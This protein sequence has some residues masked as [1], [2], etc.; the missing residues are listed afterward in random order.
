MGNLQ[1]FLS[2]FMRVAGSPQGLENLRVSFSQVVLGSDSLSNFV[3]KLVISP[4]LTNCLLR[5]DV[6]LGW[7]TWLS[8][9]VTLMMI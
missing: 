9:R 1:D 7:P 6:S 4:S 3:F 8:Q 2:C 5:L